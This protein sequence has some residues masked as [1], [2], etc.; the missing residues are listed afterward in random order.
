M[1]GGVSH[2]PKRYSKAYNKCLKSYDLKQ[3]PKHII[4]LDANDLYGCANINLFQQVGS[5]G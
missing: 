1:R 2:I 4:Y 5:N 3:E